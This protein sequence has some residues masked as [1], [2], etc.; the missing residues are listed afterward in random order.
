MKYLITESKLQK[1]FNLY[2][3]QF[4]WEV[5]FFED[6]AVFGN[7]IRYFDTFGD[8][9]S[10]HPEFLEKLQLIFGLNAGELLLN[11]FNENFDWSYHPATDWGATE[12]YDDDVEE[13]DYQ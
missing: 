9:L 11:W 10:V 1:A 13:E 6:I 4:D 2:L 5:E 12:Y 8:Y 7:G 3:D